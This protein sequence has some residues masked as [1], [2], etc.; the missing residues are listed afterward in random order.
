MSY[1]KAGKIGKFA[2]AFRHFRTDS[3]KATQNFQVSLFI[4]RIYKP[5]NLLAGISLYL[6]KQE[7][8]DLVISQIN[9]HSQNGLSIENSRFFG[10]GPFG[11]EVSDHIEVSFLYR[12]H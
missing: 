4:S 1:I 7:I 12:Q 8:N 6:F 5:K 2:L 11:D 9:G 10:F 3:G